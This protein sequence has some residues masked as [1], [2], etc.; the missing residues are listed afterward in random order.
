M[1]R[2]LQDLEGFTIGA[3]DGDIGEVKD[4]YFDDEAWVIRYLVI[5]TGSWLSRRNVL[6]SPLSIRHPDWSSHRLPVTVNSEHIKNSPGIDFDQPT[7]RQHEMRYLT[8]YGYPCYWGGADSWMPDIYPR[9]DGLAPGG[10]G[11]PHARKERTSAQPHENDGLR[12][13]SCKAIIGY[14]IKAIDGEIGHVETLLINEDS[15]AVQYLVVN[16]S[17]WWLGHRVLIAPEWIDEVSWRDHTVSLDL[18]RATIRTSPH[19][20]SSEQLNREREATLYD[21]YERI[22]YWHIEAVIERLE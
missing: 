20:E 1:L 13:R 2:S 17:N 6:I 10:I 11:V 12:L 7:S 21:H 9:G 16:T 18:K 22:G 3:T 19:Y 4:F 15:W 14:H 8:Y 5:D